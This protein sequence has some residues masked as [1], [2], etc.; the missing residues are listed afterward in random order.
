MGAFGARAFLCAVPADARSVPMLLF[1]FRRILLAGERR[2]DFRFFARWLDAVLDVEPLACKALKDARFGGVFRAH[3]HDFHERL[4][5][6]LAFRRQF[7]KVRF[8]A[9]LLPGARLLACFV[10][11]RVL[12]G[13][14]AAKSETKMRPASPYDVRVKAA[15]VLSPMRPSVPPVSNPSCVSRVCNSCASASVSWRS[16]TGQG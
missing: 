3:L 7:R 12:L 16:S 10:F 13:I 15:W 8:G 11:P 1:G 4:I 6:R 2:P 5:L 9:G 14:L